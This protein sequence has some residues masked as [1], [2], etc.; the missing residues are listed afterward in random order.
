[1]EQFVDFLV[2]SIASLFPVVDPIGSVPIFIVLTAKASPD[3]RQQYA[4]RIAFNV[5]LVSI[6]FL[7]IGGTMLRFFQVSLEAV[8]IAGGIVIFH[9]GWQ[10]M[11]SDTQLTEVEN[12]AE[13]PLK[14]QQ[15]DI[16]FMPMTM[17]LL[18][19]PGAIAVILALSA[20]A[21]Q[22][23]SATTALNLSGVALGI[24]AIGLMTYLAL[25]SSVLLLEVLGGGGIQTLNP[26]LGL[27]VMA[28]GVQ[29]ILN[30]FSGWL[31]PLT[32]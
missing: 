18:A 25:R 27:V 15:P 20:Q 16:T 30:G 4:L 13:Q 17:P 1:M 9:T 22:E 31:Q 12:E 6:A 24:I 32:D 29:L 7:L 19:G 5:I 10:T 26:L 3:L 28:I 21:G 8:R 11:N 2:R 14:E 23:V